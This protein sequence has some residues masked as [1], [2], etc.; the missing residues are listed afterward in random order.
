V[1]HRKQYWAAET[2]AGL[3]NRWKAISSRE[4]EAWTPQVERGE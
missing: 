2:L 1:R 4:F 3:L